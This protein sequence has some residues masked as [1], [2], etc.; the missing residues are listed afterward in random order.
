RGR[1]IEGFMK[2]RS[3]HYHHA[4]DAIVIAFSTQSMVQR[5][6]N[7]YNQKEL[8]Q[9]KEKIVFNSHM[10]NFRKAVEEAVTLEKTEILKNGNE[11]KRLLISR[12]PRAS[13]TGA[14]H[15]ET[16]QSPKE[17]K[18]RGVIVND[19]KGMC[20]NGDMPRVDVFTKMENIILCLYMLQIFQKRNYQTKQLLQE[21]TKNG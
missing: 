13:I 1:W 16:I 6:S 15:K 18:G 12:P 9:T 8:R 3:L 10:D 17:Y 11:A 4:I 14:A 19:G 5:L 7:F 20:D 2:D 21:K